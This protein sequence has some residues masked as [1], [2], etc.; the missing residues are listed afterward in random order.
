MRGKGGPCFLKDVGKLTYWD[1]FNL[2][3]SV[4]NKDST[5]S[6]SRSEIS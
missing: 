3:L 1:E 2:Y 6:L 5:E 4:T